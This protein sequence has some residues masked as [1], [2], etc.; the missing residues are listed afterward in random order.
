MNLRHTSADVVQKIPRESQADHLIWYQL[1]HSITAPTSNPHRVPVHAV[2]V[3]L[4]CLSTTYDT[5]VVSVG[6][7]FVERSRK[8]C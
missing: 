4:T 6:V 2:G 7:V 8:M 1:W 3:G 5:A